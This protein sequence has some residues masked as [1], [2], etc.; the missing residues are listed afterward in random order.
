MMNLLMKKPAKFE[1]ARESRM[2]TSMIP[3][4]RKTM[5][6]MR[7]PPERYVP[8][9]LRVSGLSNIFN[10]R[11][12][13]DLSLMTKTKN[14]MTENVRGRRESEE[15]SDTVKRKRLLWMMKI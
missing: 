8:G 4:R 2:A 9:I 10:A 3:A 15:G 6:T 5:M 14:L 11:S 7:R 1:H 13:K 12:A